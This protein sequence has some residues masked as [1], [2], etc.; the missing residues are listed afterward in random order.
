MDKLSYINYVN[1]SLT[2]HDVLFISAK[3]TGAKVEDLLS[4]KRDKATSYARKVCAFLFKY[5][6][7]FTYSKISSELNVDPSS[8]TYI[9]SRCRGALGTNGLDN[10]L[11]QFLKKS[12]KLIKDAVFWK[13]Q[14]PIAFI[15]EDQAKSSM[16]KINN[17]LGLPLR[18]GFHIMRVFQKKGMWYLSRFSEI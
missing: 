18:E 4:G 9:F 5:K 13:N 12:F 1:S 8:I 7:G 3:S 15:T 2:I 17:M 6:L 16:N 10:D 14:N 11:K